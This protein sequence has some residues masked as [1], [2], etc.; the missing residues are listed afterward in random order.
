VLLEL[1]AR[2]AEDTREV[3]EAM[4]A[5]LRARDAVVLPGELGAGKTTFVQGVARGLGIEDQVSSPTFTLVKE[6]RG[7][8]DIAHVDVYRLERVQDVVDLGLDELGDGEGVLLVEWGD[9]VEDLLPDE[10]LRV[11]LTTEDLVSDVRRLRVSALGA[12][13]QERWGAL[14]VAVAPWSV[15]S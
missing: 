6:Y 11:E 4:S 5:S 7:I 10:R 2:T 12:S 15:A 9:A 1:R 14:E 13:W 3:G 8:L